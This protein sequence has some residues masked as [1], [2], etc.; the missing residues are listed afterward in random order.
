MVNRTKWHMVKSQPLAR[1]RVSV[2]L[3]QGT[4]VGSCAFCVSRLIHGSAGYRMLG[5]IGFSLKFQKAWLHGLPAFQ[6]YC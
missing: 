4:L 6:G 1:T 3:L 5:W 2:S